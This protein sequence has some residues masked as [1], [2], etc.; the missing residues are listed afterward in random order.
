MS[1]LRPLD[2]LR[3]RLREV[4][5]PR[6]IFHAPVWGD[7]QAMTEALRSIKRE[8]GGNDGGL[9][10]TDLLQ[11]SLARF[12]KDGKANNFTQLKYV[13]H[14]VTVPIGKN[15]WRLI[16]H[17]PWLGRLLELV[18]GE[19]QKT[20]KKFRRCYQG[21]LGGY[22]G[23][24]RH[25]EGNNAGST[26]WQTLRGYLD[27]NLNPILQASSRRG[28]TPDWLLTLDAH[29]N[30]LTEDPCSRYADGL[31]RGD[32]AELKEVCTGLGI[33]ESSWVWQDALMA[34][35]RLVCSRKDAVFHESLSSFMNLVNGR[36]DLKLP[37]VLAIRATALVV[38]RYAKCVDHSE[39][40]G[41][42]DTCV[43]WIGNPWLKRTAWDAHVNDEPARLMVNSWLKRRLIRDFFELLAE[44]GAADVR[45]LN[46]W[47]SWE[48]QISEM[49]FFL[50]IHAHY[51]SSA[52][53]ETV[54]GR[55]ASSRR[56]LEER[57]QPENNAV[58]MRI[59]SLVVIE[60]TAK[61]NAMFIYS[62][63]NALPDMNFPERTTYRLKN[64]DGAIGRYPHVGRWEESFDRYMDRTLHSKASHVAATDMSAREEFR[65]NSLKRVVH[66]DGSKPLPGTSESSAI[67]VASLKAGSRSFSDAAF[68]DIRFSCLHYGITLEDNRPM[69]GALWVLLRDRKQR[70]GF[71]SLLEQYGFRY[72]EGKGYWLKEEG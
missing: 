45:R 36:A 26:N 53:L 52:A 5:A 60:F 66:A 37:S 51:D 46:Y 40:A 15:Q 14:G 34:Y 1:H 70:L 21:L 4:L 59:G 22:F 69:G 55:M 72:A 7:P 33:E 44:D 6:Q 41:L 38:S 17:Q 30:L 64:L 9:P 49:W 11:A 18:D 25:T 57:A 16:D 2:A 48:P 47:L 10:E 19:A 56:R 65:S 35:V 29:R 28:T 58:V 24:D 43:H 3:D 23:F 13:C 39:H 20:P 12:A 27:K 42:R 71:A 67:D 68:V 31:S 8:L 61:N 62:A 54:R 32:P 63:E 50:G